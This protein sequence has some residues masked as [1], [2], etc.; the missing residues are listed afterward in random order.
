MTTLQQKLAARGH[1]MGKFDGIL[2]ARTRAAV[3]TEQERLG[4]PAD[5]WPDA[6]LLAAL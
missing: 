6:A 4:L 1:D 3:Q 5:G 2:G